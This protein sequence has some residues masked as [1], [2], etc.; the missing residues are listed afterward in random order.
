MGFLDKMKES[1]AQATAVAKDAAQKGQAKL[2]ALQA[3]RQADG[4]LRD[5]GAA[6]YAEK[7]GRAP[8]NNSEEIDR[9]H[10][11]LERHERDNGQIDLTPTSGAA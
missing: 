9:L 7:T 4:L 8:T 10:A 6:T 1:A 2:D 11:S 3:K 5:L